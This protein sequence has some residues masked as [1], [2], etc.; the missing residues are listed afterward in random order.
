[1]KYNNKS[2]YEKVQSNFSF[3]DIITTDSKLYERLELC[4]KDK[5]KHGKSNVEVPLN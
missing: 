5:C 4:N 2:E 3:Y 1:M